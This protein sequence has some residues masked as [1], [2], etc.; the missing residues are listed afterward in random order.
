MATGA[1][2][3]SA[4][5]ETLLDSMRGQRRVEPSPGKSRSEAVRQPA[6]GP[7]RIRFMFRTT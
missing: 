4:L 6:R 2:T 1:E 3:S 5:T 7:R